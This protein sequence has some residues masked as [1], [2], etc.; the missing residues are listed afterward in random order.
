MNRLTMVATIGIAISA[1]VSDVASAFD[2]L[3]PAKLIQT[4]RGNLLVAEAGTAAS[5]PNSGRISIVDAAGNRR[6]LIE[7]LPSAPTNAANTPSGPSGLYLDGQTLYVAI[8]EGNPTLPGPVPRT[9]IPNPNPASP[10]FSSVLAVH[11][12]A[13]VERSTTGIALDL[14]DHFALWAGLKVVRRDSQGRKI[15]VELIV[16]FPDY[17]PEPLPILATNVRHSHPYGVVAD[18]DYLYVVD[19]GY[20]LVHKAGIRSGIFATLVSFPT[21]PNPTSFGPPVIENVP[22]SIRWDRERLLVTIMSGFP[23]VAGLSEVQAIDPD[24]GD[25]ATVIGGL[26]SAIDVLPITLCDLPLGYLTLEYSQAQ[27]AG[28]PG[29]LQLFDGWGNQLAVL[30]DDLITP[31]SMVLNRRKFDVAVSS[32]SLGTIAI[33]PIR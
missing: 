11:Y 13:A 23:F 16:D 14:D 30:A 33:V 6:T 31:S 26:T 29:R 17:V 18:C 25:N 4:P 21:T 5:A 27:L 2:L 19:G 8:G 28:A 15:T 9:E 20:N 32:I 12:S 10:I 1:A 3:R 24:T 7:G 22:T